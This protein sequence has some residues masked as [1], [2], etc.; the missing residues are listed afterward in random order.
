MRIQCLRCNNI[1]NVETEDQAEQC[2]NCGGVLGVNTA[3]YHIH[4]KAA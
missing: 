2:P 4:E 3:F 1:F